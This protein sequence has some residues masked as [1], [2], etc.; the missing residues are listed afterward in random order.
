MPALQ[1]VLPGIEDDF[2]HHGANFATTL[3]DRN[4]NLHSLELRS[5]FSDTSEAALPALPSSRLH[6]RPGRVGSHDFF[7]TSPPESSYCSRLKHSSAFLNRS[8]ARYQRNTCFFDNTLPRVK[9]QGFGFMRSAEASEGKKDGDDG[10]NVANAKEAKSE[11]EHDEDA[12]IGVDEDAGK[13]E[14]NADASA[15]E[16]HDGNANTGMHGQG[17]K[18]AKNV[19][20]GPLKQCSHTGEAK[21]GWMQT[22]QCIDATHDKGAKHVCMKVNDDFCEKT[23]QAEWC[24]EKLACHGQD[25]KCPIVNWCVDQWGF[26]KYLAQAGGCDAIESL[27]C[28]AT[29]QAAVDAFKE[30]TDPADAAALQCLSQMC[31]IPI[32]SASSR[33]M[34]AIE[35][36]GTL[37]FITV[38]VFGMDGL[39]QRQ[40][41]QWDQQLEA[42]QRQSHRPNAAPASEESGTGAASGAGRDG[43]A[44]AS[45]AQPN[46]EQRPAA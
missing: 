14:G 26:S 46:Q 35:G 25:G 44:V 43:E 22:G 33:P 16:P 20:G 19:L 2:W 23:G 11:G 24:N 7:Q 32:A 42:E 5:S 40:K 13:D 21:T 17:T 41:Q 31:G 27:D 9:A 6:H 28:E 30:S 38:C 12:V 36:I 15:H 10:G 45:G 18:E 3:M 1:C 34:R 39:F 37:G 8:V 4:N 29:N